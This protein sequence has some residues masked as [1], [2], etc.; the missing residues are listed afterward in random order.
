VLVTINGFRT[1]MWSHLGGA[2]AVTAILLA[3]PRPVSVA[4]GAAPA[5]V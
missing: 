4:A 5:P 3:R 2:L 1:G